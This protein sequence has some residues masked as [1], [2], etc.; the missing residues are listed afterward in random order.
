VLIAWFVTRG[1]TRPVTEA[2]DVTQRMADGDL[3]I[4]IDSA[5]KDEI[6]QMLAAQQNLIARLNQIIGD[7][8]GAADNLSNASGQVSATAQSLSQSSSEQAA[9]A[10]KKPPPASSR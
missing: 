4:R 8:K 7:V 9:S 2:L 6:G 10:S 5:G 1:I 3:T